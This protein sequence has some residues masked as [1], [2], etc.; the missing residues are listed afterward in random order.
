MQT[1]LASMETRVSQIAV[2][3]ATDPRIGAIPN[4][5]IIRIVEDIQARV[6]DMESRFSQLAGSTEAG[7]RIGTMPN[8]QWMLQEII[9]LSNKVQALETQSA[10]APDAGHS[11]KVM[12]FLHIK[13]CVPGKLS[14]YEEWRVWKADV[15]ERWGHDKFKVFIIEKDSY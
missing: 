6:D 11:D 5:Q 10:H 7:P 2:S 4:G 14:K 15:V 3:T 9:R 1:R 12:G 13:D 8:E